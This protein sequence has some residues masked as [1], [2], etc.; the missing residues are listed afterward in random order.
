M[1][2]ELESGEWVFSYFF[3]SEIMVWTPL[4]IRDKALRGET[5]TNAE[6]EFQARWARILE[7]FQADLGQLCAQLGAPLPP[8]VTR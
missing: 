6:R 1:L 3:Y 8:L 2:H 4:I 5:L 7:E